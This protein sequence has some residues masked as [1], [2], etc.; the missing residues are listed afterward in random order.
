MMLN[1]MFALVDVDGVMAQAP[2]VVH[3]ALM[4]IF[5][6]VEIATNV[7]LLAPLVL[8]LHQISA[9]AAPILMSM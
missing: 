6:L 5:N 3:I 4:V 7:T 9:R 2:Q 8:D 1:V